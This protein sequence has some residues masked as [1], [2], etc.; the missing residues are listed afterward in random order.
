M[1]LILLWL[2]F[3]AYC[4]LMRGFNPKEIAV[5]GYC[6]SPPSLF[7]LGSPPTPIHPLPPPFT[8]SPG[9]QA[10]G[11]F[12]HPT[13]RGQAPGRSADGAHSTVWLPVCVGAVCV[14]ISQGY[15]QPFE[16]R[17]VHLSTLHA[18]AYMLA[19]WVDL[20]KAWHH[21]YGLWS[22]SFTLGFS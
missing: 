22:S 2:L 12:P 9:L 17:A 3:I 6:S 1:I 10:L 21:Q 11:A 13:V 7:S 16:G 14:T 5:F 4:F 19:G 20:Q 15:P 18:P 8:L